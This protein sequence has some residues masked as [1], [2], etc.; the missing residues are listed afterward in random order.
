MQDY[1]NQMPFWNIFDLF[2]YNLNTA[3]TY[4]YAVVTVQDSTKLFASRYSGNEALHEI[5]SHGNYTLKIVLTDWVGVTK[6]VE[7]SLFRIGNESD[8]YRLT[9]GGFSGDTGRY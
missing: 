7:Y 9:A 5:T 2:N 3:I 4:M 8:G 6:V 1:G